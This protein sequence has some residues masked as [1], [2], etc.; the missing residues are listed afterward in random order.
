MRLKSRG[1]TCKTITTNLKKK[2]GGSFVGVWGGMSWVSSITGGG[3]KKAASSF[4]RP[5]NRYHRDTHLD[6]EP[7]QRGGA[8]DGLRLVVQGKTRGGF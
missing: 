6:K 1:A 3:V 8:N 5:G 4:S 2:N 7:S